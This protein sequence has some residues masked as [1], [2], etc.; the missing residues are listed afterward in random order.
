MPLD[1]TRVP[2]EFPRVGLEWTGVPLEFPAVPLDRTPVPLDRT[3]I[4]LD[5]PA[6]KSRFPGVRCDAELFDSTQVT[7]SDSFRVTPV[8]KKLAWNCPER[9][10]FREWPSHC[11]EPDGRPSW[12]T[13]EAADYPRPCLRLLPPLDRHDLS[14]GARGSQAQPG[15]GQ[16]ASRSRG[17]VHRHPRRARSPAHAP[18]PGP[19]RCC[20][21]PARGPRGHANLASLSSNHQTDSS[22]AFAS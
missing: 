1:R 12:R 17:R 16:A 19:L 14:A 13:I 7:G 20:G 18:P 2:L 3:E 5:F 8:E 11:S 4:R 6:G 21:G 10:A 9:A 22:K 15:R